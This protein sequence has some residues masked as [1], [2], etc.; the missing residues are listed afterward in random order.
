MNG[1]HHLQQPYLVHR[2]ALPFVTFILLVINLVLFWVMEAA[3]GSD[4]VQVLR[5]FG[6]LDQVDIWQGDHYRLLSSIFL[7]I[8]YPHILSNMFALYVLGNVVE[9][10]YG[11]ARFLMIYLLSGLMGNGVSQLF[12]DAPL[13]IDE[14]SVGASGAILGLV[15]ALLT[16]ISAI[17][18]SVSEQARRLSLIAILFLVILDV[19]I[20]FALKQVNNA[21]HIGGLLGGWWISYAMVML[22]S[23][24]PWKCQLGE[25]LVS[26]FA[27]V[28]VLTTLAGFMSVWDAR[29]WMS[30]GDLLVRQ[31][32]I[33]KAVDYLERALELDPNIELLDNSPHRLLT[34]YHYEHR[35][36]GKAIRF[37]RHAADKG[38]DDAYLH[39]V[40]ERS[41]RYSGRDQE[42]NTEMFKFL[43]SLAEELASDIND[44]SHLNNLAYALA[45]RELLLDEALQ[46]AIKANELT[47]F[48]QSAYVDTL[49]WVLYRLEKYEIAG[50]MLQMI[51]SESKDPEYLYHYG[52]ILI[53]QGRYSEGRFAIRKALDQGLDWWNREQ[54]EKYVNNFTGP[55]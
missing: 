28:F 38:P 31:E 24:R 19:T 15:G 40:L 6:A 46:W 4:H 53:R 34:L 14:I 39:Q 5:M 10:Y 55:I 25:M 13:F 36:L 7:H 12:M 9:P 21:A 27:A 30:R 54:A 17:R 44:P 3:G 47:R 42:A 8:G 22:K 49:A 11:H 32:N 33:D 1:E 29:Y 51:S 37:G 18:G 43:V 45:E 2:P 50:E 41:Y 20:G 52:M 23:L 26:S 16:R 35:N 48:K